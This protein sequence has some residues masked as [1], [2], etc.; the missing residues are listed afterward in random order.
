MFWSITTLL[1]L[2]LAKTL[3]DDQDKMEKDLAKYVE[4]QLQKA[5]AKKEQY[6]LSL[7]YQ[8]IDSKI[9]DDSKRF[10]ILDDELTQYGNDSIVSIEDRMSSFDAAAARES[11]IFIED[12]L[13]EIAILSNLQQDDDDDYE[14]IE[15]EVWDAPPMEEDDGRNNDNESGSETDRK[16]FGELENLL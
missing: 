15:G 1:L 6:S 14:P 16:G 3:P 11:W 2:I 9:F 13:R 5:E 4:C 12:A 10:K 7:K 8:D